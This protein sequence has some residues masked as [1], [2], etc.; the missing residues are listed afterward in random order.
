MGKIS[1][2]IEKFTRF[3][4]AVANITIL[5]SKLVYTSIERVEERRNK[6]LH[7]GK[8]KRLAHTPLLKRGRRSLQ[9]KQSFSQALLAPSHSS[10]WF[11]DDF[12]CGQ[13][14]P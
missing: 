1:I 5:I 2:S 4:S 8:S 14:N 12:H 9:T 6:L 3:E 10:I 13:D 11:T 7:P